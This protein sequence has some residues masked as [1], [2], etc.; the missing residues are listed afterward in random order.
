MKENPKNM[1]KSIIIA[2]NATGDWDLSG[3]IP[4]LCGE[5]RANYAELVGI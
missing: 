4:S 5:L 2:M 1:K 3:I